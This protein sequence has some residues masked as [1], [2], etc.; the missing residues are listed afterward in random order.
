VLLVLW[1]GGPIERLVRRIF[2]EP[3]ADG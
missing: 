3:T 2:R 1:F